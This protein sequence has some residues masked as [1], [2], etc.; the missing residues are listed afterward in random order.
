MN[1]APT[2][3]QLLSNG[4][5]FAFMTAAGTGQSRR[6]GHVVNRWPGDPVEDAHGQFLYL[7]DIEAGEFWSVGRQPV[8][9]SCTH[10]R[11]SASA[12]QFHIEHEHSGI[13]ARLEVAVSPS[14]DLEVRRLKLANKSGR[15]RTIEVTSY[16]EAVLNWQ[17][18]DIGHPAFSKLFLQTDMIHDASTLI[19]DR[20]PRANGE[21]WPTLFHTL[22]G[23]NAMEWETDRLRFLGRGRA[24]TSPAALRGSLSGTVGNVLDPCCALRTVVELASGAEVTMSF[25]T[26][27]AET[28]EAAQGVSRRYREPEQVEAALAAAAAAEQALRNEL[29]V[30]P[31]QAERFQALAA[32]MHAGD[33]NLK[34]RNADLPAIDANALFG[35]LGLPRDRMLIVVAGGWKSKGA[36]EANLARNYFARKGFFTN[37]LVLDSSPGNQ[38]PGL[39]DRAVTTPPSSLDEAEQALM[40]TAASLVV[41]GNLPAVECDWSPQTPA[42]VGTR[43][44]GAQAVS[45]PELAFFNGFG[46]FST[47]GREY[48]V[49][50]PGNNG[51]RKWPPLP[52]INVVA[53]EHAG[54]LVTESGAGCTW[55]RNSQANR[56]TPWSNEPVSDPHGEALYL[57]DEE[58]GVLFSPMPGPVES[59]LDFTVRHGFG[60]SVF[61]AMA[62]TLRME[63][64]LFVPQ[65]EPVKI[66]LLKL[67]NLGPESRQ[68]SLTAY[69]ELVLGSTPS[70]P[71][72]VVTHLAPDGSLRARNLAAGD[73]Q[74]GIAF[75]AVKTPD[76]ETDQPSQTCDRASFLGRFGSPRNPAALQPGEA[77]DGRIG[78]GLDPCF[79]Q[80]QTFTIA[81]GATAE[82]V[83]LLGEAMS[84]E[85]ATAIIARYRRPSAATKALHQ[86]QGFWNELLGR[87]QVK[88]P[89]KKLD[90]LVNGWLPYQTLACRLWARSGFSQSSGAFGFRDQLQDAGNLLAL[91]PDLARRQ[92]AL[93]ARHQFV[94]GDVLHWWHPAPIGRGLRTKFSD[95]LLWLPLV[96]AE[97]VRV[98]GDRG[99]LDERIPFVKGPPLHDGEDE[100]YMTPEKSGEEASLY[101]HCCRTIDRS[102]TTGTHGLPLMGCGDWNDGMNRVGREGRGES[103]WLGFFLFKILGDFLPF[104]RERKDASRVERYAQHHEALRASLNDGGWDGEWYRRAYYD[105]G[106]PLGSNKNDECRIDAIAQAWAVI[107]GAAPHDRARAAVNALSEHLIAEHDGII[108]LLTPPFVN[109]PNDP[110]YIKGYVAGIRENGGQYTHGACWA[111]MAKA[112]LGENNEALKLWEMLTPISH[113]ENEEAATRYKGE[114]FVYPGD[115]YGAAPHVGRCG[116]T[117]YTG[118]SGWMYRVALESILGIRVENGDT[119]VV[120][121]CLPDDWPSCEVALLHPTGTPGE[122]ALR[123][124]VRIENPRRR[125]GS[126]AEATSDGV[127]M[128]VSGSEV[129]VPLRTE[130]GEQKILITLA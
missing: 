86:I 64:T 50:L 45:E 119:L 77:F 116:W 87:V 97:Y 126:I 110:G 30:T 56:I 54:F 47:D 96:T 7:R 28:R 127:A 95:D 111:I 57:R 44:S 76:A 4:R 78:A 65:E 36:A 79:A 90:I 32:A 98:T 61:E 114:P 100:V 104:C 42:P 118:S 43:A 52:W 70:R 55:A 85:A 105:N 113:T 3:G 48:V 16:L 73:F 71:S 39:D 12:G 82:C 81:P 59:N 94:E 24:A 41:E 31:S 74:D 75:A 122:R 53:N 60:Y 67:T 35:R 129:R 26:G 29:G 103:V 5:Y 34:G 19:V 8:P 101:E 121:P 115:V 23:A 22:S 102:L 17:G 1:H 33:R 99:L 27:I 93:H 21:H 10:Y 125:A 25:V 63:T 18:A 108:R 46:G 84:E 62:G 49:R 88:T 51:D 2:A 37:L 72:L 58:T 92:I 120:N 69:Q 117:W 66:T 89:S 83:V 109:T 11:A 107:S 123:C 68:L 80:Q 91:E 14:D 6:H 20:R 112:L 13:L 106:D 40:R 130:P 15:K 124:I 128:A 9:S 38:P